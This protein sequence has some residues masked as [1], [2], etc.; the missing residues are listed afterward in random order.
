MPE[1]IRVRGFTLARGSQLS[2]GT[3]FSAGPASLAPRDAG[4]DAYPEDTMDFT[5]IGYQGAAQHTYTMA[6]DGIHAPGPCPQPEHRH[7]FTMV[8]GGMACACGERIP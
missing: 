1:R 4:P 7:W 2:A 5:P 3:G 6:C 8:T